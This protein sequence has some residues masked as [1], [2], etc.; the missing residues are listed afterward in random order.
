MFSKVID[1]HMTCKPFVSHWSR[2]IRLWKTT[3]TERERERERVSG[4]EVERDSVG[5]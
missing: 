4:L 1:Y 3:H 5:E 2:C